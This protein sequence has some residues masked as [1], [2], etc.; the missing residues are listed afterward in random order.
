MAKINSNK[1]ISNY[2]KAYKKANNQSIKV[3]Y[4]NGYFYLESNFFCGRKSERLPA[5]KLIEMTKV[6]QARATNKF[7]ITVRQD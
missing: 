7:P 1:L 3:T 2:E 5:W 6:L 4:Q